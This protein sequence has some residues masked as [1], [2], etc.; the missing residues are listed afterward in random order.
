M[1]QQTR[2]GKP[3]KTYASPQLALQLGRLNCRAKHERTYVEHQTKA[4]WQTSTCM[5]MR[6]RLAQLNALHPSPHIPVRR[7][8]PT[9]D[10]QPTKACSTSP[11]SDHNAWLS[12]QSPR[13]LQLGHLGLAR[14]SQLLRGVGGPPSANVQHHASATNL[15]SVKPKL[16]NGSDTSEG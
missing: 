6:C 4:W 5:S 8:T 15:P 11:G 14:P 12:L 9:S 16:N 1:K 2:Q 13:P 3:C 7:S 10:Q